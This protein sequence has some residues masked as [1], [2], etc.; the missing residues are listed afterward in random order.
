MRVRVLFFGGLK[1]LAGKSVEEVEL[2]E[3]ARVADLL[4]TYGSQLPQLGKWFASMAVAVNQQY[5]RP[6]T[7]LKAN[8]EVAFLPPVS[9][10]SDDTP[11][12]RIVREPIVPHDIIPLL[13]RPQDGAIVIF[14]GMVRNHSRNRTT[15][16]LE[17]DAYESMAL[18]KLQELV[19]EAKQRFTIRNVALV[20]R[21]GHLE[22]GESSVLIAVF[23]AHRA[24]AFDACRWII[25][26]LKRTVPIWKKE[27]FEDGAVWA[28]GDPFP[29]EI[30]R[31]NS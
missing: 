4:A 12:V 22:V 24:D 30:P 31:A 13:E 25:D 3:G 29:D 8:D 5:A 11:F 9:G 20:H 15:L 6:E 1:E 19:A 23:S 27:Y 28:D 10:G 21:L 26:T 14:D 16:Y 18:T 2:R 17:Y 7:I